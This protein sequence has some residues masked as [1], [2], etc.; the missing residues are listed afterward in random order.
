MS[1]KK[2][3]KKRATRV[4]FDNEDAAGINV[5]EAAEAAV[6]EDGMEH[7]LCKY[8]GNYHEGPGGLVWWRTN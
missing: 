3:T 2:A 8:D 6:K 1:T 5:E 4:N 7:F